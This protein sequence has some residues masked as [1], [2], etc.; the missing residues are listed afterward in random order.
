MSRFK[1]KITESGTTFNEELEIDT[2]E[3][4]ET[5]HV[6]PHNNV[7]LSDVMHIFELV[8]YFYYIYLIPVCQD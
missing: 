3:K 8:R 5:F 1:V 2:K 7:D 4:I 6:A